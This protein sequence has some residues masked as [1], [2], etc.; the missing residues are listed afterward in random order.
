MGTNG[1]IVSAMPRIDPVMKYAT[2]IFCFLASAAFGQ[3]FSFRDVAWIG[4]ISTPAGSQNNA[5]FNSATHLWHLEQGSGNARTDSIGSI[6]LSETGGTVASAT[7]VHNNCVNFNTIGRYLTASSPTAVGPDSMSFWVNIRTLP[8]IATFSSFVDNASG[9]LVCWL[10]HSG[11]VN[12]TDDGT[13]AA[14]SD[15]ITVALG[16]LNAWHLI[17]IVASDQSGTESLSVD[18]STFTTG[19]GATVPL[20][21]SAVFRFGAVNVGQ[22][23]PLVPDGLMDEIVIW[24]SHDVT[25]AEVAALFSPVWYSP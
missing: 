7:G 6:S 10:D 16:S 23:A 13:V 1:R 18:G 22:T 15:T 21:Q 17:V 24:D 4:Y 20:N 9:G 5:V 14:D 3:G 11:N 19:T 2:L 8:A 12:F 25:Q